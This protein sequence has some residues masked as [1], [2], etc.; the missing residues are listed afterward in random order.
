M[1]AVLPGQGWI[2]DR[3]RRRSRVPAA[4]QERAGG[5]VRGQSGDLRRADLHP[6]T[7]YAVLHPEP[8]NGGVAVESPDVSPTEDHRRLDHRRDRGRGGGDAVPAFWPGTNRCRFQPDRTVAASDPPH[9]LGCSAASA[10]SIRLA[11]TTRQRY[12]ARCCP[13]FSDQRSGA[14]L[15]RTSPGSVVRPL[16]PAPSRVYPVDLKPTQKLASPL[17]AWYVGHRREAGYAAG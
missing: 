15:P 4:G 12:S 13:W 5:A 9:V 14:P 10:A 7:G 6:V 1:T 16:D 17:T 11:E 3:H 8:A 2:D